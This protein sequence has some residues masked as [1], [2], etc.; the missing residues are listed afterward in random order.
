MPRDPSKVI[1]AVMD[2]PVLYSTKTCYVQLPGHANMVQMHSVIRV[3][4]AYESPS[5]ALFISREHA[6]EYANY[7]T[8]NRTEI[9]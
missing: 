8:V 7:L 9:L 3:Y 2:V 4:G 5:V 6:G 1:P